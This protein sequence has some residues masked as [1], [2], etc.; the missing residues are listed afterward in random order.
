[1]LSSPRSMLR[2]QPSFQVSGHE[3]R[4]LRTNGEEFPAKV[5]FG[6]VR[7]GDKR[8]FTGI[9]RDMTKRKNMTARLK[10]S[11]SQLRQITDSV[12]ALIYYADAQRRIQFHNRLVQEWFGLAEAEVIGRPLVEIVGTEAYLS[13]AMIGVVCH[14]ESR[15]PIAFHNSIHLVFPAANGIVSAKLKLGLRCASYS[16]RNNRFASPIA[17]SRPL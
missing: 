10:A 17:I 11:E 1:M 12:P 9:V 7:I 5:S 2:A 3:A 13:A 8:L 16:S 4:G 15:G 6:D 14:C